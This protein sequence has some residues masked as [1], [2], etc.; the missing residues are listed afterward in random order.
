MDYLIKFVSFVIVVFIDCIIVNAQDRKTLAYYYNN[1]TEI[2]SDAQLAFREGEYQRAEEIC[3]CQ[4]IIV[5]DTKA[6]DLRAKAL[7]CGKLL[8]EMNKLMASNQT[9][10]ARAIA[11]AILEIN[12]NDYNASS[13]ANADRTQ[14]LLNSVGQ[15]TSTIYFDVGKSEIRDQERNKINNYISKLKSN[16]GLKAIICGFASRL[17]GTTDGNWALSEERANIVANELMAA[18]IDTSRITCYWY[19]DSERISKYPS[20]NEAVVLLL[21]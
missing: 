6:D 2:I 12:P 16:L 21:K 7:K 9:E 11:Q 15:T 20:K 18:G 14:A 13:V 10:A 17:Q 19:G 3:I 8:D 5:G 1:P 4:F